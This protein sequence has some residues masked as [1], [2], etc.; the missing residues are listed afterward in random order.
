MAVRT[1]PRWA[2]AVQTTAQR[3]TTLLPKTLTSLRLAGWEKPRLC[4]DAVRDPVPLETEFGLEVTTHWP[5][6]RAYGNWILGLGELLIRNPTADRFAIFQDD[7]LAYP[8]LRQYLD[9]IPFPPRGYWN[10]YTATDNEQIIRGKPDGWYEAYELRTGTVYHGKRQQAGRGALGL[11][12][13]REGAWTLLTSNHAVRRIADPNRGHR[14]IDGCVVESMNQSGWREFVHAPS[15]L[16]H[17]GRG[18]STIGGTGHQIAE[19]WRGDGYDAM[20]LLK[21]ME[22]ACAS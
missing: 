8:N 9:S 22:P 3:L 21:K 4:V 15:L 13:N 20:Q 7:I 10:L 17:A 16:Q 14:L 11:V 19:S 18:V 1:T 2:Y 6:I 12:F 5:Q